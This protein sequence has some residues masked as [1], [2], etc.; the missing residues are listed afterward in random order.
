MNK[1]ISIGFNIVLSFTIALFAFNNG[2]ASTTILYT[3]IKSNSP[4]FD[5][6]NFLSEKNIASGYENSSFRPEEKINRAEA[7][8]ML[9]LGISSKPE[10]IKQ[11]HAT[12]DAEITFTDISPTA[13]YSEFITKA[14]NLNIIDG[15]P[16]GSFR[17]ENKIN[18]AESIKLLS[19]GFKIQLTENVVEPPY[20]DIQ[21]N[22]W[23]TPYFQFI[24]SHLFLG[25]DKKGSVYP[26][27]EITRGEFADLL[28]HFMT[29]DM[30]SP[31]DYIFTRATFYG[32]G[33]G[34]DGKR[35]ASGEIFDKNKYTA[36][37]RTLPFGTKIRVYNLENGYSVDVFI[38]DRGP[39]DYRFELDLS[40]K[41]FSG[42][43]PISRGFIKVRF[44]VLEIPIKN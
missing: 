39:Y 23:Y 12:A 11:N 26:E 36:A 1:V 14:K 33:D 32:E 25:T 6:V 20:R 29:E 19:A 31:S 3:D 44:Q 18:L 22:L 13:W 15:Y 8:K 42:L 2:N 16:D 30:Y 41:A 21:L 17:P 10:L 40:A 35:T 43:A 7:V 4:Y 34:F 38:N 9:I 5:A 28:Y 24:K 37:H 27:K